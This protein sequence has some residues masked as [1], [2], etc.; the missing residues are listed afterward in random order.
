MTGQTN[1]ADILNDLIT[2]NKDRIVGYKEAI[3][4]TKEDKEKIRRLFKKM[5]KQSEL[6]LDELTEKIRELG[7]KVTDKTTTSGLIYNTWMDIA[8]ADADGKPE[9]SHFCDQIED[10]TLLAY[11]SALEKT[12][13]LDKSISD[14]ILRQKQDLMISSDEIKNLPGDYP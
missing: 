3:H 10:M 14:L 11:Q 8:Y 12:K 6:F 4:D 1:A 5:V 13:D 7:A 9:I 2:I